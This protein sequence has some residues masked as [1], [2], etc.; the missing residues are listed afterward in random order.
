[1]CVVSALVLPVVPLAAVLR[2]TD[3][4]QAPAARPPNPR[5]A[6]AQRMGPS[7]P[8]DVRAQRATR[9]IVAAI[10]RSETRDSPHGT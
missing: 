9:C 1:M 7:I 5:I 8:P 3:P 2:K 10:T 6:K 4:E